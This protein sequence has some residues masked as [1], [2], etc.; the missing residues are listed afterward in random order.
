MTTNKVPSFQRSPGMQRVVRALETYGPMSA[1]KLAQVAFLSFHTLGPGGYLET[2]MAG[3]RIYIAD[4]CWASNGFAIPVFAAG[5]GKNAA[6]PVSRDQDRDSIGMARIVAAL[7]KQPN[8]SYRDCAKA[9]QLS[10]NTIISARYMEILHDQKRIHVSGWHRNSP[11]PMLALY[12][13]GEGEDMPAPARYT[14]AERTRRYRLRKAIENG[15]I[16][17]SAL[18]RSLE[19]LDHVCAA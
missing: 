11:G 18:I 5:A 17:L 6:K 15:Q 8:S 1:Q 19:R 12:S 13:A 3:N 9:A 16:G 14:N 4:W 7:K 2:L 10:P